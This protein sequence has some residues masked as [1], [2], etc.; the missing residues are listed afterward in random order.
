MDHLIQNPALIWFLLGLALLLAELVLP[1]LIVIFFGAGAWVAALA[2]LVFDLS[3]NGQLIVFMASS[4]LNLLLL[5]RSLQQRWWQKRHGMNEITDEFMGRTCTVTTDIL[6]GPAGGK[7][8]FKG[9]T[10]KA[11]SNVNVAAGETVRIIG[12]DSIVLLVEP[13]I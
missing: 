8:I 2:F 3:F 4:L 5:R 1:G 7:V 13:I 10:W 12:K 6:P 11:L 9:T